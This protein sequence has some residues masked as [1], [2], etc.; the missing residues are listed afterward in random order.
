[1]FRMTTKVFHMT[2]NQLSVSLTEALKDAI[3]NAGMSQREVSDK[4]GIPLVTLNR[5]L[6]H[7][8]PFNTVELGAIS[9]AIGVSLVE[10]AVRA[11]RAT[12]KAA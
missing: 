1:M 12:T 7:G 10:L 5:K 3:T 4:A 11:E 9:E 8:A 6:N 2:T